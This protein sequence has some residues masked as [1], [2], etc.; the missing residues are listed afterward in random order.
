MFFSI[1]CILFQFRV[2]RAFTLRWSFPDPDRSVEMEVLDL[3][4]ESWN[5]LPISNEE[6]PKLIKVYLEFNQRISESEADKCYLL[7][8]VV[9]VALIINDLEF[10]KNPLKL[11]K[12]AT[13][14]FAESANWSSHLLSN[15]TK[16]VLV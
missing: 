3:S 7:L 13:R 8:N 6:I 9:K 4:H 12:R 5:L 11:S 15:Y 16:P 10:L 1:V 14:L 2:Y